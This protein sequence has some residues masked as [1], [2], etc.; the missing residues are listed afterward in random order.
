[1][2]VKS[3]F[4]MSRAVIPFMASQRSGT[5]INIGSAASLRPPPGL[6]WYCATKGAVNL[7]T[8]SLALEL[9]ADGIRV[10]CVAPGIGESALLESFMGVS[11]TP[12]NRRKFDT[13]NP[14]G[15][16]T[17]PADVANACVYLASDESAYVN[18]VILPVDGGRSA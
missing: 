5:I 18:G 11:D 10:N 9:A 12:G 2:N 14:L 1:V 17:K 16:I 15:R 13:M 7:V 3:I 8:K 6:T 4:L